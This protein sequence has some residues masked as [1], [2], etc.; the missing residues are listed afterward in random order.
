MQRH[1]IAPRAGWQEK[2]E[3]V[4]LTF[5]TGDDG[6][7][8]WDES[9]CYEFSPR[10]IDQLETAAGNL[11]DRCLEAGDAILEFDLANRLALEEPWL[12]LARESWESDEP[13]LY[14]RFDFA[15]D[16][17]NPPKL[18]EFNADTP[19]SLLEASVAQWY[20]LEET[21]PGAD[22]FNSL[23][24]KLVAR[25]K[26]LRLAGPVHFAALAGAPEDEMTA[27]YLRDTAMQAGLATDYVAVDDIGW[28]G[29][30]FVDADR[31]P[32][33][34]LFKL[35]PWEWL[36][37]DEYGAHLPAKPC[38][39][40]EPIWKMLFSNKAI[41][42]ILWHLFPNHENLLPAHFSPEKLTGP[43]VRKPLLSREG[44]NVQ[45]V[46]GGTA[47]EESGGTYGAEGY[48]YQAYAPLPDFG[49]NRPVI[50]A[51]VVGGIP[52][53]IGVRESE[54][55]ITDNRSRFVPHFFA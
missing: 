43:Y 3:K 44:A 20:W 30:H 18:L 13:Q 33:Q 38:R 36:V 49:G 14:G 1:S 29:S 6:A 54:K 21:R 34:N 42:A 47:T 26:E 32:I 45:I 22:Q 7:V 27:T 11:M 28:D 53:G 51:W 31:R 40:V 39:I 52:A 5:H 25:W 2:V 12:S 16:G 55:R 50:G 24:E 46:E 10:Q 48:V 37:R 19:T 8:Y 35:Y 15:Y 9:A 17:K 41:L 23:H 4:G